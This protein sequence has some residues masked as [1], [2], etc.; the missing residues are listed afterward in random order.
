MNHEI[1]MDESFGRVLFL[2]DGRTEVG[3]ALDFGLRI[4]HL[5]CCGMPNLLYR[6]PDDCSDGLTDPRGWRIF[7]G[8]RFWSAPESDKSYYPD[9]EPVAYTLTEDGAELRQK[10]DPWLREEKTIRI[11]FRPD[12][13][14]CVRHCLKNCADA[15]VR[16]AAWGVSTT[17]GGGTVTIPFAG[18][19]NGYN[20]QRTIAL[21]GE[22]S[23]ADERLHF[24]ADALTA[25]HLP[26]DG[27]LKL[28]LY[29][30]DARIIRH[31]LGQHFEISIAPHPIERCADLGSNIELYMDRNI[32]EMET[33][34][35]MT[36]LAPGD[37][38]I[39]EEIW[40]VEKSD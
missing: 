20:P 2:S 28:G 23:L 7:G 22:T 30:T 37:E 9:R 10:V 38:T 6:Q 15:P 11:A 24:T 14:V 21:W 5:S 12:G 32:L 19:E 26:R 29:C 16:A 8:H 36:E 31:N 39:H 35:E 27:Y 17:A 3:A 25:E 18:Q 40:R 33:L 4:V 13:A 34:G 1:R